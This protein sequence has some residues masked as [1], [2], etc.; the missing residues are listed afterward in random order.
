MHGSYQ[1]SIKIQTPR[2]QSQLKLKRNQI[3]WDLADMHAYCALLNRS[4]PDLWLSTTSDTPVQVVFSLYLLLLFFLNHANTSEVDVEVI[5]VGYCAPRHISK[6]ISITTVL[7]E[8]VAW[9]QDQKVNR[10]E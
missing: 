7:L 9:V 8:H 2:T 4:P 1:L 6:M 10:F 3:C 5:Q